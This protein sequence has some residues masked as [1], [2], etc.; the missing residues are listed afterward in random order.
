M[1]RDSVLHPPSSR[2]GLILENKPVPFSII[3]YL[4]QLLSQPF[5]LSISRRFWFYFKRQSSLQNL[6]FFVPYS[7]FICA[8]GFPSDG[9]LVCSHLDSFPIVTCSPSHP[10][11]LYE[12]DGVTELFPSHCSSPAS[13]FLFSA[14]LVNFFYFFLDVDFFLPFFVPMDWD[15]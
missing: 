2:E 8:Q 15:P 1:K 12:A 6:L 10:P 11:V 4:S 13:R 14:E 9:P 7:L 5:N 3:R